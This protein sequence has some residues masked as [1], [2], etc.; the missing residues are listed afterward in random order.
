MDGAQERRRSCRPTGI[1]LG[2]LKEAGT[3]RDAIPDERAPLRHEGEREELDGLLCH[4]PAKQCPSSVQLTAAGAHHL[5]QVVFLQALR[6]GPHQLL[7][8]CDV[9]FEVRGAGVAAGG[10]R[11]PLETARVAPVAP[12]EGLSSLQGDVERGRR[13]CVL[14]AQQGTKGVAV[15]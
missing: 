13:Q 9:L 15:G 10:L 6:V 12:H 11:P 7:Q 14:G 8:E 3:A 4:N 1:Y 2:E 5:L